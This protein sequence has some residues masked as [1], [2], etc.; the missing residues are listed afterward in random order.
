MQ[1]NEGESDGDYIKRLEQYGKEK[2]SGMRLAQLSE[3][4]LSDGG[5]RIGDP[6]YV[7][8]TYIGK[9]FVTRVTSMSVK[10]QNNKVVRSI[11]A[12]TPIST[13]RS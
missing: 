3:F 2:L 4:T 6:V 8:P 13:G 10:A 11:G 1:P 7:I 9:A 5:V 12:G